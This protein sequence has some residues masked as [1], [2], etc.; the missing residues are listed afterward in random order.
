[1]HGALHDGMLLANIVQELND[2][3][4]V[5]LPQN[6]LYSLEDWGDQAGVLVLDSDRTLRARR[7]ELIER[8]LAQPALKKGVL[9]RESPVALKLRRTVDLDRLQ[10]F[11][12]EHGFLIE[13]RDVPEA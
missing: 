9:G 7:P 2:R 6:V 5:P 4:R 13:R 8:F 12:R 10:D 3:S 11:A 1:V